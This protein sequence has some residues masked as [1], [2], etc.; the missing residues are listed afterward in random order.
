MLGVREI[1]GA[2]GE[3]DEDLEV[4]AAAVPLGIA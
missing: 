4:P 2:P 3:L 1:P